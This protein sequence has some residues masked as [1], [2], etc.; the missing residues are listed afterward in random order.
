MNDLEKAIAQKEAQIAVLSDEVANLKRSL[1]ILRGGGASSASVPT[2]RRRRGSVT[3]GDAA[4]QILREANGPIHVDLIISR[5]VLQGINQGKATVVSGLLKDRRKRFKLIGGN[6][7][8]LAERAEVTPST[9]GNNGTGAQLSHQSLLPIPAT[10]TRVIKRDM[11][12]GFSLKGAVKALLPKLQGEIS[13]PVIYQNL[14]ELYPEA[15]STIKK[16]SIATTLRSLTEEGFLEITD[17]GQGGNPR[18][19]RRVTQQEINMA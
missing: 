1:S 18:K 5:L 11:P 4:E 7:F 13:Q 19:Y 14:Q 6:I 12:K 10:S 2:P 8:D 3:M 15:A 16:A 9:N 17:M